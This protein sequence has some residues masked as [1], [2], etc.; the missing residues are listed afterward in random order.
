MSDLVTKS[1]VW[2]HAAHDSIG[3]VRKYNGKP[4]WVHTDAVSE[5]LKFFGESEI[6]QAAGN[7]HDVLEDVSTKNKNFS[8]A[9]MRKLFPKEVVDI[10][11][12][13]TDVFTKENYQSLNRTERHKLELK[14]IGS[15]SNNA[16]SLKLA[17]ISCNIN[18]IVNDDIGFAR[19]YLTEKRDTLLY[20]TGGNS[21]ILLD[22]ITVLNNEFE[23]L[24]VNDENI[25]K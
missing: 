22:V 18:G 3:Q 20:L 2:A 14:R 19:I 6:V 23:Q 11:V 24:Y 9:E 21:S 25:Q 8:E 12:D 4:Y 15:V 1:K 13:V 10:V 7:L 17:D 5:K 16:K